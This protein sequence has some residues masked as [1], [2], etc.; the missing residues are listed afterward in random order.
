VITR[1]VE[2]KSTATTIL[3]KNN[4]FDYAELLGLTDQVMKNGRG[5]FYSSRN[6]II[7]AV[8]NGAN[9]TDGIDGLRLELRPYLYWLGIL[10]FFLVTLFF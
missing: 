5:L 8:S 4:E 7:T 9:L 2:E 10:L 6:F 1:P 3:F